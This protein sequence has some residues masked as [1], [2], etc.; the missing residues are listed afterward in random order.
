M[1]SGFK[2]DGWTIWGLA[3]QFLFFMSFAVQWY[4]SEKKGE[5]FLPTEFWILR[6]VGSLMLL[7]YVFVRRDIVLLLSLILQI[8]MYTRNIYLIATKGKKI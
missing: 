6:I 5:S 3:S 8:A 7:L 1:I 4:K 2:L